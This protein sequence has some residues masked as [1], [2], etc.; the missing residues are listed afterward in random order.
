MPD[1][2][3][4]HQLIYRRIVRWDS[5]NQNQ[6]LQIY[7]NSMASPYLW[8]LC[9]LGAIP[10]VLFWRYHFALKGFVLLFALSYVWMYWAIVR[11]K[12][13]DYLISRR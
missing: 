11:Y 12:I 7:R 13:P 3:H 4:L 5:A 10:A 9:L 8:L 2:L 1:A 6:Q